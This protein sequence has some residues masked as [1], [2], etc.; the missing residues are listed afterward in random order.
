[1]LR[2]VKIWSVHH[3]PFRNPACSLLSCWTTVLVIRWMM[4]LGRISLSTDSKVIPR[5]LLRLLRA[6][7]F[8]IFTMTPSSSNFSPPPQMYVK[9]G[10]ST[11]ATN[12]GF[13]LNTSAMRL[14]CPG[15]FPFLRDL[16][17]AMISSFPGGSVLTSRSVSASCISASVGG[18]GLFRTSLKCSVPSCV[19]LGF[20]REK[21]PLLVHDRS[22]SASSVPATHQLGDL[23]D[24][25]SL[26]PACC[27]F[28]LA[29]KVVYVAS[30]FCSCH[31][32]HC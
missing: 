2:R 29:C 8:G 23:A 14:S 31:P 4:I 19:L 9:S 24:S 26:S 11:S 6:P 22:V 28:C 21:S 16:M 30:L 7:F 10:W 12:Y 32:L 20:C 15:D 18:G 1:M 25:A 17:T 3:F 13:A 27:I 5:Q